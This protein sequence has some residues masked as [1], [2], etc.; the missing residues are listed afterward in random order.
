MK[1]LACDD[2]NEDR[3]VLFRDAGRTVELS[4]PA[5]LV[6]LRGS[7]GALSLETP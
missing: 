2:I 3:L 1:V 4:D 6:A 5:R 7:P